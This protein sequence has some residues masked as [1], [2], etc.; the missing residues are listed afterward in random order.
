MEHITD[1][2]NDSVINIIVIG[3]GYHARRIYVPFFINEQQDFN[4]KLVCG[5]DLLSQKNVIEEYLIGRKFSDM[6]M[7]YTEENT[8]TDD[9]SDNFQKQLDDIILKYKIKGIII[10]TEPLAHTK[11]A[12]WALSRSLHILMDKPITS[13][14][15][16]ST[17]IKKAKKILSDYNLL[18]EEY[19]KALAKNEGKLV[20][21]LM[22]QRRFHPAYKLIRE[23]ILE[24]SEKTN[25]PVTSMQAFHSDGQWRL[26]TEIVEQDYHPYNQ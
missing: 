8:E 17:D 16:I 18:K 15:D 21:S 12:K 10:S 20:F 26:P 25:C 24:V 23:L 2:E 22:A 6:Q 9:L 4:V 3:V 14:R 5:L 19:I 13:E 1:G 11:Y 7:Y